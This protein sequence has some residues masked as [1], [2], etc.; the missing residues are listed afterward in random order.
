[1][2]EEEP[3]CNTD[4]HK[5]PSLLLTQI[6]YTHNN[7][8]VCCLG[9][10][11]QMDDTLLPK[12]L[13]VCKLQGGRLSAGGQERRWND[14]VL[15]DMKRCGLLHDWRDM[16]QERGTWRGLVKEAASELNCSRLEED[17]AR[18]KALGEGW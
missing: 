18:K 15:R 2:E 6:L 12:C 11:K 4:F 10:V 16:A 5:P 8:C 14:L 17:E 7:V 1:M 13:L 3:I 9:H